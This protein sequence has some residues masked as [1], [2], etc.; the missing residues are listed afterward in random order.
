MSDSYEY[1]FGLLCAELQLLPKDLGTM[2]HRYG[3]AI[4]PAADVVTPEERAVLDACAVLSTA[5]LEAFGSPA[6]TPWVRFAHA[7]LARRATRETK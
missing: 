1:Q 5:S 6:S 4:V 7:E 3:L 2:L